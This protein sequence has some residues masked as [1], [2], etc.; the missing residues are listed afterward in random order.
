MSVAYTE[1]SN[2]PFD[3]QILV[4]QSYK[5]LLD[6][7]VAQLAVTSHIKSQ[8]SLKTWVPV[9]KCLLVLLFVVVACLFFVVCYILYQMTNFIR[10]KGSS[11]QS[12]FSCFASFSRPSFPLSTISA[13]YHLINTSKGSPHLKK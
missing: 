5:H 3:V 8:I 11:S 2:S 4:S 13:L 1:V 9:L 10:D 6:Q 12:V 7:H